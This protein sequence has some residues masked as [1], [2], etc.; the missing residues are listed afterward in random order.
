MPLGKSRRRRDPPSS[1]DSAKDALYDQLLSSLEQ[2]GESLATEE[3]YHD[4]MRQWRKLHPGHTDAPR[5]A[6][7]WPIQRRHALR[8]L[9]V[10]EVFM[11]LELTTKEL[12][13]WEATRNNPHPPD[14]AAVRAMVQ[15]EEPAR[16][17]KWE[18]RR[19]ALIQTY[20]LEGLVSQWDQSPG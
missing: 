13:I 12:K 2:G 7:P 8:L 18:Q 4:W 6:M 17:A 14:K 11:R 20:R 16:R 10:Q 3:E 19:K 5:D 9:D 1:D 15:R